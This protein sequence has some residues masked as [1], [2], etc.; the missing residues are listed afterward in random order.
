M[1]KNQA[2]AN[3]LRKIPLIN[4][5]H[6]V[7]NAERPQVKNYLLFIMMLMDIFMLARFLLLPLR[8]IGEYSTPV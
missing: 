3:M 4:L 5:N 2:Q 6:Q 8:D 7:M 1:R